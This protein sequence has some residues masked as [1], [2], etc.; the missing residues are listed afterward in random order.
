M[1]ITR[2][3]LKIDRYRLP[4][5]LA[6]LHA[7]SDNLSALNSDSSLQLSRPGLRYGPS[8][9]NTEFSDRRFWIDRVLARCLSFLKRQ[10][11]TA[12][13]SHE[14]LERLEQRKRELKKMTAQQVTASIAALKQRMRQ[15]V[16]TDDTLDEALAHVAVAIENKLQLDLRSN[17]CLAARAMLHGHCVEMATGE[18][19]TLSIALAA[20]TA[21]L[22]GTPVHVLTAND[23]LA[24]RDAESLKAVYDSLGLQVASVE[25]MQEFEER[26]YCYSADIVYV[27]AKQVAFDWLNDAIEL[28]TAPDS[29]PARLAALT[30]TTSQPAYEPVLRGLCL[31]FLDEADSLLVDEA[32][33]PLVLAKAESVGSADDAEA[34]IAL[35]LAEQLREG[36]DYRVQ[37]A[38]RMVQLTEAGCD[39]LARISENV[40]HV[41]QSS[42]YR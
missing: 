41:W 40:T 39:E 11:Y 9:V 5:K 27:T 25:P 23:Y 15:V 6:N 10:P 19:K 38:T 16:P 42:R 30:H 14:W 3:L 4:S 26:R 1:N 18:G 13:N 8:P 28:G 32:R 36:V 22:S 34:A 35:G 29:L 31:A 20:G 24:T 21:A 12:A 33:I 17:Q 2:D 37:T 7:I